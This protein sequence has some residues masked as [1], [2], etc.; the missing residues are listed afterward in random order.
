VI[1]KG[2][3]A[4]SSGHFAAQAEAGRRAALE[5]RAT[6][7]QVSTA[8]TARAVLY[9]RAASAKQDDRNQSIVAQQHVCRWRAHELNAEVIDEFVDFG[10]GMSGERP[11][12]DAMLAKLT[13][14][15]AEAGQL[16]MYVIAR[17]HARIARDMQV[18]IRVTWA[19]E[20]AGATLNIASVP[21]IEYEAMTGR[22][23][24]I[25]SSWLTAIDDR[26]PPKETDRRESDD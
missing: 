12:L 9:L 15:Q 22:R 1:D 24:E 25:L 7:E 6:G 16:P 26:E 5:Q 23:P 2:T 17:D 11:G 4:E 20:R 21:I 8:P 13:E 18:Y 14:L 10:S 19:I 3:A